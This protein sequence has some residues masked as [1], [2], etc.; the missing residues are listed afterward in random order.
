[1]H[2][3][4]KPNPIDVEYYEWLISQI[5]VGPK[6]EFLGLFEIMHNTQFTWFVPN[7]DNRVKDGKHLRQDFFRFV[8]KG[9]KRVLSLEWVSVLEVIVALSRRIAFQTG[10]PAE[11][12]AWRLIKNLGLHKASDPLSAQK[13]IYVQTVL[14]DLIWRN[15]EANGS[16]GFFPLERTV[17][18]QTKVE[19]WYQMQEYVM[20]L[21]GMG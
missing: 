5:K 4:T 1:M 20:E 3:S 13:T 7:D 19:I 14:D 2:P 21:E 8:H 9:R 15:Y 10:E 17:K 6:K 18:D 11:L 16:G 12:W